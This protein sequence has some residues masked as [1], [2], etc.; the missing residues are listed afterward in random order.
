MK[1]ALKKKT[2]TISNSNGFKNLLGWLLVYLIIGPFLEANSITAEIA[3]LFLSVVLLSAIYTVNRGSPLLKLS[4]VVVLA[5][6]SA[7]WLGKLQILN[8][9]TVVGGILLA[10][11]LAIFVYSFLRHLIA[12]TRVDG[13]VI[14]AALCLYLMLGLLWGAW[15][16]I[17]FFFDPTAL[18]GGLLDT[19][20]APLNREHVFNYFS[21]ITLST[22][23]YGDITPQS[24]SAM[25]LCQTE[26]IVG[27]FFSIALVARLVGLHVAQ[28]T[29][30]IEPSATEERADN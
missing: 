4:V 30:P 19:A 16:Q 26:A 20:T 3:S 14:C 10:A 17:L 25:A 27:Q 13:N 8:I 24:P 21:F 29:V 5:T 12:V 15:Y 7:I 23:G 1:I 6:L 11:Y 22:L 28:N 18:A 9:P 2:E